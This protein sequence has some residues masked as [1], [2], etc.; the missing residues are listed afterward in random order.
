M[1]LIREQ[2][3]YKNNTLHVCLKQLTR[4]EQYEFV[5]LLV[6]VRRDSVT[7]CTCEANQYVLYVLRLL[8]N[9]R[10]QCELRIV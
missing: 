1:D 7:Y 2:L 4:Q 3:L 5:R 8:G 6:A 10:R 9:E